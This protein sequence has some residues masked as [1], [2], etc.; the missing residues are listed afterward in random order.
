MIKKNGRHFCGIILLTAVV[1][2]FSACG[3][4]DDIDEPGYDPEPAR[5][6]AEYED[7]IEVPTLSSDEAAGYGDFEY[8]PVFDFKGT[9]NFT[10]IDQSIWQNSSYDPKNFIGKWYE[11]GFTNGYYLEMY[12]D[13]TWQLFMDTILKGYYTV[14]ENGTIN[15]TEGRY[16]VTL[17]QADIRGAGAYYGDESEP[18]TMYLSI[19][20]P[21]LVNLRT[22]DTSVVFLRTGDSVNNDNLDAFYREKYPFMDYTGTWYLTGE[23]E[24]KNFFEITGSGN[25]GQEQD[26]RGMLEVGLLEDAGDN[27]FTSTGGNWGEEYVFEYP[28]D[29]YMYINGEQYERREGV[30]LRYQYI[31]D[32]WFYYDEENDCYTDRGY[33]FFDDLTFRSLPGNSKQESGTYFYLDDNLLLYDDE[34]YQLHRFYQ[35]IFSARRKAMIDDNNTD[36]YGEGPRISD[37]DW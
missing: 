24:A 31:V 9:G 3:L 35:N 23:A 1:L 26:G 10:D 2:G 16:G 34:G 20:T 36:L 33:E 37:T 21:S 28:G 27:K 13:G 18:L 32:R 19:Y 7:N 29:G 8:N 5:N 15:F 25:W 11:D 4:F 30:D 14:W 22:P 17:G 12:G 6:A